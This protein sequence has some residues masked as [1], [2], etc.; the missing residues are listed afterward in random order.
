MLVSSR[1]V[2]KLAMDLGFDI[3]FIFSTPH[4][5]FTCVRLSYSHLTCKSRLFH[6][7]HDPSAYWSRLWWFGIPSEQGDTGGPTSIS[8]TAL[9]FGSFS[10]PVFVAHIA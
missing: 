1:L 4:Q 10:P 3:T 5:W 8:C 9:H 2:P 6:N 7:A